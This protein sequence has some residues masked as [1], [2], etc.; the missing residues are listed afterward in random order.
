MK[1]TMNKKALIALLL[2]AVM[3]LTAVGC[4]AK[5][6]GKYVSS[7]ILPQSLT[8]GGDK[9]TI[10]AFGISAQ[11]TYSIKGEIITLTYEVLGFETSFDETF[12]RSGKSIIVGGTVFTKE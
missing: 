3:L 5:L 7:G 11:G 2:V 1:K 4:T 9:V 6:S 12:S 10:E 8:F